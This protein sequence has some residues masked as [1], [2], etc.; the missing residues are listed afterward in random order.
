M[1]RFRR[2]VLCGPRRHKLRWS[3][4]SSPQVSIAARFL[5]SMLCGPLRHQ[6]RKAWMVGVGS[7]SLHRGGLLRSRSTPRGPH[8]T[9]KGGRR[10][11][12]RHASREAC[13]VVPADACCKLATGLVSRVSVS[14]H[15]DALLRSVFVVP[16]DINSTTARCGVLVSAGPPRGALL[17][18]RSARS[19]SLSTPTLQGFGVRSVVPPSRHASTKP[20]V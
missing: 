13:H 4:V 6:L 17:T 16:V 15:R 9:S 20:A 7:R 2:S 5:R 14:P 11:P 3:L 19:L 8:A 18:K 12:S 10:P 1:A